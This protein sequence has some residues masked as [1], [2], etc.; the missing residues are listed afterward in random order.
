MRNIFVH[1][2][3]FWL[4]EPGNLQVR[5]KFEKGLQDL[6]QIGEIQE[7]HIGKPADTHRSVV[8]NS[9]TYSLLVIFRDKED[10]DI[11]QNHP[12]H[13][14]F[15]DECGSFWNRIQVFDSVDPAKK[16]GTM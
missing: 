1:H 5:E 16:Q 2:V 7:F 9:Y 8:E 14:K 15:I 6:L 10:H 13:H 3:F 12:I 11:Y 4:N